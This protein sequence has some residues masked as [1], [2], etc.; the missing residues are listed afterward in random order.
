VALA[1]PLGFYAAG[2]VLLTSSIIALVV[3]R[4]KEAAP[5]RAGLLGCGFDGQGV[6]CDGRF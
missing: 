2:G 3:G 5:E 1:W 4:P 6:A